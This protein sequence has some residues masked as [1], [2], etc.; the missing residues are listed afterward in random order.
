MIVL[1]RDEANKAKLIDRMDTKPDYSLPPVR[2]LFP[3]ATDPDW[4]T[5]SP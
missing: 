2:H 1:S 3:V 4:P 5:A